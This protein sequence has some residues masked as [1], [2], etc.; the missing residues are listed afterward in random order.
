LLLFS[1]ANDSV[2]RSYLKGRVFGSLFLFIGP[3][4]N[5]QRFELP[6][7][8]ACFCACRSVAFYFPFSTKMNS[9]NFTQLALSAAMQ[10]AIADMGFTDASP[11]QSATIP[12][13][14]EGLDVAG[15]AQTGTGKTAA[16]GIPMIELAPAGVLSSLVLCPTRELAQQVA[17]ELQKLAKYRPEL[18][19]VAVYGGDSI[20]RQIGM[21]K[22]GANIVVGTPG[23]LKDLLQRNVLSLSRI[24]MVVLDEA[25]EMLNM[26]F[27]QDIER[28][29]SHTPTSRQT[30]LLSATMPASIL[31]IAAKH[32]R[33]P[34]IIRA[35]SRQLTA[36]D[37][38]QSYYEVRPDGKMAAMTSLVTRHGLKGVMVFCN[39]KRR[40]DKLAKMLSA[41]GYNAAAIH[42][43]LTQSRRNAV[44]HSFR[45]GHVSIL[46]ATDVAARGL[47]ISDVDG[48]FNFDL[49]ME[50]QF[51]VHRIGRT[52]R[53]GKSGM[54]FSLI[55]GREELHRLRSIEKHIKTG[56]QRSIA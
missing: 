30:V 37:I 43:D 9:I 42:G 25:D 19:I 13:L 12:S 32:Q 5:A 7:G 54:A 24:R 36:P 33:N 1:V 31:D 27:R 39:T 35:P 34:K 53:A 45:S 40:T 11:V 51:Y 3:L 50:P 17:G 52:G 26:G 18:H 41:T 14:L 15:Q 55:T 56:I 46:V 6:D 28:L 2:F 23:R 22:R 4:K 16:F 38:A 29:L 21:L 49:P 10:R 44:L 8:P 48:V 47:D 20:G